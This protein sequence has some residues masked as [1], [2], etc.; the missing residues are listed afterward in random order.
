MQATKRGRQNEKRRIRNKSVKNEIKTLT[1]T[2]VEKVQAKDAAAAQTL[3]RKL[4]SKLDKAAK[5]H[6][7]H[8]NSAA[9]RKSQLSVLVSSIGAPAS[10]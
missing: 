9:R 8:K 1:K 10:S 3:F 4:T 5:T 7:Y 6:L 2:L